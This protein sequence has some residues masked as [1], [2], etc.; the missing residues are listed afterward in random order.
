MAVDL[1]LP[2]AAEATADAPADSV[3]QRLATAAFEQFLTH[4]FDNTTV[5]QIAAA[6]GLSRRTYF[7]YFA[8]K[9]D[10]IFPEHDRLRA[11]V[12]AELERRQGE[13][14]LTAV[15]EAVALVLDDYVRN[16]EVSLLRF[17]LTRSVSA[18]RDRE[19]TSVHRYQ[20]LFARYLREHLDGNRDALTVEVMAA[21][22]VT[23]H[24]CVLRDWLLADAVGDPR[25]DLESALAR[26]RTIFVPPEGTAPAIA[27]TVAVFSVDTPLVEVVEAIERHQKAQS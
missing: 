21:T 18:L 17:T 24:N 20:R 27:S 5:D 26:V 11:V 4:G 3:R 14:P 10:V 8:T 19:V 15:C 7:R 9:E 13:D 12:A 16:R 6:A 23:A 22:I 2:S 1:P 25:T